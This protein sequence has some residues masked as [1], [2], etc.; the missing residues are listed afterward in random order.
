MRKSV[1]RET[2]G[3]RSTKIAPQKTFDADALL[4]TMGGMAFVA[5]PDYR[6]EYTNEASRRKIGRDVTGKPC[7]KVFHG[8]EERCP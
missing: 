2:A 7:F 4:N 6:I 3:K 1:G 8:L 5:S